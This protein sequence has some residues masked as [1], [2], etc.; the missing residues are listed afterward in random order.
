M[1]RRVANNLL[2]YP[3]LCGRVHKNYRRETKTGNLYSRCPT[4][5]T[6]YERSTMKDYAELRQRPSDLELFA[7]VCPVLFA[8]NAM[9]TPNLVHTYECWYDL[10]PNGRPAADSAVNVV[11]PYL[12]RAVRLSSYLEQ[13]KST[14]AL[15]SGSVQRDLTSIVVQAIGTIMALYDA[16][17]YHNDINADNVFLVPW[18]DNLR[19]L[20]YR[21]GNYDLLINAGDSKYLVKLVN[22]GLMTETRPLEQKLAGSASRGPASPLP[23]T[24][25]CNF[26][27]ILQPYARQLRFLNAILSSAFCSFAEAGTRP[28]RNLGAASGDIAPFAVQLYAIYNKYFPNAED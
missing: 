16:N 13:M 7:R 8:V 27:A 12:D 28:A 19:Q 21:V 23:W 6:V 3:P 22:Y 5:D 1:Y 25:I 14:R 24:D 4:Q 10:F 26:L 17:L 11:Q 18:P 20:R 9:E 2:E 15:D